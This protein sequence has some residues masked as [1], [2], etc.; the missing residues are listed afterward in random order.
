MEAPQPAFRYGA[1]FDPQQI[2]L[3]REEHDLGV[4]CRRPAKDA[5][6]ECKLKFVRTFHLVDLGSMQDDDKIVTSGDRPMFLGPVVSLEEKIDGA[7]I[8]ISLHPTEL[9]AD[10]RPAFRFQKR[11]HF[12]TGATEAQFAGLEEWAW[13]NRRALRKLL[14]LPLPEA[15]AAPAELSGCRASL[16]QRIV[17]GEWCLAL[18]SK[19]Y[20][21]L[22]DKF[23]IFDIFDAALRAGRGGFLSVV[24]R[25]A[26]LHDVQG[27]DG[28]DMQTGMPSRLRRIRLI[29]QRPFPSTEAIVDVLRSDQAMSVY[30]TYEDGI[31]G[32]LTPRS[33]GRNARS[34]GVYLRVDDERTGVL[35]ARCKIVHEDFHAALA[36]GRFEGK[37]VNT[38]RKDLWAALDDN[39]QAEVEE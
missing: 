36:Q 6:T 30:T 31:A 20:K 4:T 12:V 5:D 32:G 35:R 38:V 13:E 37:G 14:I 11:A 22:C 9:A 16:G 18:H 15:T 2:D 29:A 21:R 26:M 19:S 25:D 33:A 7:N 3:T 39:G 34:E 24:S 27:S 23:L 10:E 8:G 1:V 17:F 28:M